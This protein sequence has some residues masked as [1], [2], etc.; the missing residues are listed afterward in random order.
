MWDRCGTSSRPK[1]DCFKI[2]PNIKNALIKQCIFYF[3]LL[4]VPKANFAQKDDDQ[5][6]WL[7]EC[8]VL[9]NKF[10]VYIWKVVMHKKLLYIE[11]YKHCIKTFFPPRKCND[12]LR[13][14]FINNKKP[15]IYIV[16]MTVQW[17]MLFLRIQK[18]SIQIK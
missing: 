4:L 18:L 3:I 11:L 10:I 8:K 5:S 14:R 6:D 9:N 16:Y 15:L 2:T 1:E 13:N 7:Y 12:A 17:L